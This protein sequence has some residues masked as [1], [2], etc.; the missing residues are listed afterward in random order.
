MVLS[1]AVIT[2]SD[3]A[4]AGKYEDVS[5]PLAQE[6]LAANSDI[7]TTLAVVPDE[8][9]AIEAEIR[10]AHARGARAIITTGGTGIGPRDI[11]PDVTATLASKQLPGLVEQVRRLGLNNSPNAGL[12][13][14]IAGVIYAE[15]LPPAFIINAPGSPGG[16]RD[17]IAVVGPLL[18]HIIGQLDGSKHG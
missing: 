14:A 10:A 1:V 3:R 4:A 17:T 6:L 13:R 15:D 18:P 16:V 5:G 8:A 9:D 12:S 11:T 2:I 7:T